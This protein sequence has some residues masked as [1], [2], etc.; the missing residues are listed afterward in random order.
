[1]AAPIVKIIPAYFIYFRKNDIESGNLFENCF[2]IK[3]QRNQNAF[4]E[5]RHVFTLKI[6]ISTQSKLEME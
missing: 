1:M 4:E 6:R 3:A 5:N 2:E